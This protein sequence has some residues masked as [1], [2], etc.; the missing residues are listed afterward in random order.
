MHKTNCVTLIREGDKQEL[1][2]WAMPRLDKLSVSHSYFSWLRPRKVYDIDTNLHGGVRAMVVTG[3]MD[4][5][6][7]MN[8]YPSYLVKACLAG[9]IERMEGLGIYEV[10]PEDFALCEFVEP[11]KLEIQQIIADGVE[12]MLKEM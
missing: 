1:L 4:K 6:L 11:S 2:G 12:L 8:I 9:D 3:L 10:L 5:Y 7:P